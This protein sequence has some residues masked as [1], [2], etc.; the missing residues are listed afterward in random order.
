VA[1]VS[2]TYFADESIVGGGERWPLNLAIS[3]TTPESGWTVDF[4]SFGAAGRSEKLTSQVTLTLLETGTEDLHIGPGTLDGMSWQLPTLLD[5]ADLVHVHQPLTRSGE[6]AILIAKALGKPLCI[7]DYGGRSSNLGASL[8]MLTLADAVICSSRFGASIL[9][10]ARRVDIVPGGVDA[11]FFVPGKPTEHR[12][13]LL[14]AGRI[15]PHKGVD[16][17]IEALPPRLPL[18]VC[19]RPDN[20]EYF[21]LLVELA[22]GKAVEFVIDAD[23]VRLRHLYQ[24][25]W[26]TILPSVYRDR[27]GT[28]YEQ[29]E[30]MGLTAL[31]SMSCATPVVVSDVG[32]LPEFVEHGVTGL[33]ASSDEALREA[34]ISMC[35]ERGTSITMG[36]AARERIV[37][38]YSMEVV[39]SRVGHIYREVLVGYATSSL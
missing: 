4:I 18:V 25:A 12:G 6:A 21:E 10:H 20:E 3:L 26:A 32:A 29:P 34:M 7:T 5:T 1:F 28:T 15:L 9:P 16:R 37:D 23:D 31:E 27:F 33:I 19:G 38:S 30:L 22:Q 36:L 11:S 8:G 2:P 35:T 39:A 13:H 24:H 14:Y 17:I